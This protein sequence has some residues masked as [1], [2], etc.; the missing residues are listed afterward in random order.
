MFENSWR[1]TELL[2]RWCIGLSLSTSYSHL[3]H[4][5][6]VVNPHHTSLCSVPM[7]SV[8]C[9][10]LFIQACV[11][12]SHRISGGFLAVTVAQTFLVFDDLDCFEECWSGTLSDTPH[13]GLFDILLIIKLRLRVTG[14][15]STGKGPFPSCPIKGVAIAGLNAV[16]LTL[17]TWL[18]LCYWLASPH[19]P[20]LPLR[21]RS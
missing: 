3:A 19:F 5:S 9:C 16:V 14:K 17:I 1:S 18:R 20:L 7:S 4:F 10:P 13:W 8:I 12:F 15:K 6:R 11:T 21:K 2:Q